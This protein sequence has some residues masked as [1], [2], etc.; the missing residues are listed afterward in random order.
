MNGLKSLRPGSAWALGLYTGKF[1]FLQC[2]RIEEDRR[3]VYDD[4]CG[5]VS[6]SQRGLQ[7][8]R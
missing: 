6:R 4:E 3:C 5:D 7:R 1:A 8:H 2:R